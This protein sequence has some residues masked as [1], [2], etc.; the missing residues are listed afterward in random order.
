MPRDKIYLDSDN[1][2]VLDGLT[3]AQTGD[4]LDDG[5]ITSMKMSIFEPATVAPDAGEAVADA[6]GKP[7]IKI[8]GHTLTTSNFVRIVGLPSYSGQFDIFAVETDYITLDTTYTNAD[9]PKGTEE[10]YVGFD[11]D[12]KDISLSYRAASQGIF[13][14]IMPNTVQMIPNL[15]YNVFVQTVA[16]TAD[17]LSKLTLRSVYH[18]KT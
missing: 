5:D 18:P 13:E 1:L 7:K 2:I 8:T 11:S 10:I 15:E 17:L 3:N 16:G 4:Y 6:S 12:G 9:V 14:G